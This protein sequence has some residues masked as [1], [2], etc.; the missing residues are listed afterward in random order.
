MIQYI[1]SALRLCFPLMGLLLAGCASLQPLPPPTET[2]LISVPNPRQGETAHTIG[3]EDVISITV[4]GHQDLSQQVV[5]SADGVFIY[6]LL[7]EVQATGRTARQLEAELGAKLAEYV[8]NPQVSVTV[9]RVQSQLAYVVGEVKS[10]GPYEL[11]HAT[12]LVELLTR[13]GGPTANAGWEVTVV[14]PVT[15]GGAKIQIDLEQLMAGHIPQPVPIQGGDTVYIP[16]AAYF[17]VSGEVQKP[18]RYRLERNTTVAKALIMAG[19]P[20]RFAAQKRLKVRRIIAGQPQ[21]F[22]ADMADL[23]QPEDVLIVP[24]SVF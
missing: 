18:G 21:D 3:P 14:K 19:G 1:F 4:Y 12:T 23:L 17:Y 5:V 7:G 20:S 10:P 16:A 6:P 13:A 22:H 15:E 8:V 11:Q 24:E 2:P 9:A